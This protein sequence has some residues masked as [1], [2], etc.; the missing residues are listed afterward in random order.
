M[1]S[2]NNGKVVVD[3][4]VLDT[5]TGLSPWPDLCQNKYGLP[6]ANY[7]NETLEAKHR[8][9]VATISNALFSL[10]EIKQG[11]EYNLGPDA[12]RPI[13]RSASYGTRHRPK[14]TGSRIAHKALLKAYDGQIAASVTK[15]RAASLAAKDL[16]KKTTRK[17]GNSEHAIR[18]KI[19][20]LVKARSEDQ[21]L[22]AIEKLAQEILWPPKTKLK[23]GR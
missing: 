16:F 21:P 9:V 20:R 2:R 4:S 12:A 15:E 18:Q 6:T 1:A 23:K 19:R 3:S 11:I 13:M 22:A 8:R 14:G 5:P 10:N 17:Y 7:H